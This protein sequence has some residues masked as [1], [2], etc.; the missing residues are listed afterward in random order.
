MKFSQDVFDAICNEIAS[1]RSLRSICKDEG[2][3]HRGAV[4]KWLR[5]DEALQIQYARAREDQA[6]TIFDECLSIADQYDSDTDNGDGGVDHIQRARLRIDT[7]KWM[8]G[9]MRPKKYGDKLAIGGDD[10]MGP[11][12]TEETGQAAAKLATLLSGIAERSGTTGNPAG[13]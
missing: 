8:A 11:I 12:K 9:K 4:Q 7:R 3:P 10:E 13:E 6:D 1:G 5:E 2:M